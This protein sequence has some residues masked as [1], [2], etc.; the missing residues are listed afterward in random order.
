MIRRPKPKRGIECPTCGGTA[1]EVERTRPIVRKRSR[2]R[3][4]V[5]CGQGV[6]THETIVHV[7]PRD[8]GATGGTESANSC[9]SANQSD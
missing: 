2:R 7:Y 8:C 4:C 5:G 9:G 6:R 3:V 1:W